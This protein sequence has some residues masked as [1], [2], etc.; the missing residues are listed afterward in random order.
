[1][2]KV[3]LFIIIAFLT[4]FSKISFCQTNTNINSLICQEWKLVFYE[5]NGEKFPPAPE[6]EN[7]RMI[8]YLDHKVKS[9]EPDNIQNGVWKY[10]STTQLLSITDNETAEIATMK[11]LKLT[12]KEI[13]LEYKAPDGIPLKM[14]LESVPRI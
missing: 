10:N 1:M 12:K 11:V 3:S 4:L 13:V 7:S 2:K 9:I 8:F 14:Y 6:Q 5:Q